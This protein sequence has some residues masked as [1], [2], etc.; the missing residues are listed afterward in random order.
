MRIRMR[1][2]VSFVFLCALCFLLSSA[3]FASEESQQ[4][5]LVQEKL[6]LKGYDCDSFDGVMT[7]GTQSA[8]RSYQYDYG[9]EVT[10]TVTDELV[11]S[12]KLPQL[13]DSSAFNSVP[14]KYI[15]LVAADYGQE[16][17]AQGTAWL[18]GPHTLIT[19]AHVIYD[20]ALGGYPEQTYLIPKYYDGQSPEDAIP[21]TDMEVMEQFYNTDSWV[22]LLDGTD[23]TYDVAVL[24]VE[25]DLAAKC[26]GYI[27][28]AE[29]GS[30]YSLKNAITI[31]YPVGVWCQSKGTVVADV[32]GVMYADDIFCLPGASGSPLVVMSE[33]GQ[34]ATAI[35]IITIGIWLD[36]LG[37]KVTDML[38]G[39]ASDFGLEVDVPDVTLSGTGSVAMNDEV[40]HNWIVAR[41]Y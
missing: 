15:F 29:I 28:L 41:T 31:G 32:A 13:L 7:A 24:H 9:L 1:S 25:E 19:S 35:G 6:S 21:A 18:A 5:I 20:E 30:N 10:G 26:G 27:S 12:L 33:D 17:V 23:H 4:L 22:S 8:I 36:E 38:G 2:A 37:G 39:L 40:I 14:G 16:G 34:S 3:A 11:S